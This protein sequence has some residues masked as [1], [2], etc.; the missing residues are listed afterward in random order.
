MF[1]APP[2]LVL[3]TAIGP[4]FVTTL[5]PR[6]RWQIPRFL[7]SMQHFP[8]SITENSNVAVLVQNRSLIV[9]AII[10]HAL[11]GAFELMAREVDEVFHSPRSHL[12]STL[13]PSLSAHFAL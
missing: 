1:P 6:Y 13:S 12:K 10:G 8:A 5:S 2:G 9:F 3:R 11:D 4:H 7:S